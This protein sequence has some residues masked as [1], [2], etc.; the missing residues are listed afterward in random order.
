[1][2]YTKLTNQDLEQL[3]EQK[4]MEA[5]C[6]MADRCLNG[7]YGVEQNLN[8]AYQLYHRAESKGSRR[9]YVGLAY[10]YE[11]GILFGQNIELAKKYYE[12]AG[13]QKTEFAEVQERKK[14]HVEMESGP[15]EPVRVGVDGQIINQII[16]EAVGANDVAEDESRQHMMEMAVSRAQEAAEA[17]RMAAVKAQEAAAA[18]DKAAEY[19][20]KA[21]L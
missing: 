12:M 8:R 7:T 4:D 21:C 5:T 3:I 2:D 20:K 13:V 18:A 16:N 11:N 15:R 6:E 9:A 14:H 10:M 19:A 1:M 17:A